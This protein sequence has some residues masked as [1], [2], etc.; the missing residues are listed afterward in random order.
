MGDKHEF[1]SEQSGKQKL[2]APGEDGTPKELMAIE[3]PA[4]KTGNTGQRNMAGITVGGVNTTEA[5]DPF[6][7][8]LEVMFKTLGITS[9]SA[10]VGLAGLVLLYVMLKPR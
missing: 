7:G 1:I 10:L 5:G 8:S 9:R 4:K 2:K 3:N 6:T